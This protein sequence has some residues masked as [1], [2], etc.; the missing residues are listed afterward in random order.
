MIIVQ[1][2]TQWLE[3]ALSPS[4]SE[5]VRDIFDCGHLSV[6]I[7]NLAASSDTLLDLFGRAPV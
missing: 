2:R 6:H 5:Y 3:W 1:P 4:H 7:P